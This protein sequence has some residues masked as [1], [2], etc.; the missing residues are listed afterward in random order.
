MWKYVKNLVQVTQV[1]NLSTCSHNFAYS[2]GG[3]VSKNGFFKKKSTY[4]EDDDFEHS[5]R[6]S[7]R[8]SPYR[9]NSDSERFS[10]VSENRNF[11]YGSNQGESNFSERIR[12]SSRREDPFN[13]GSRGQHRE[14]K[15]ANLE[16]IGIPSKWKV[17]AGFVKE[18]DRLRNK[19]K[20]Q[21][22]FRFIQKKPEI[23]DP[24]IRRQVKV[25]APHIEP[26][27]FP[28]D[29]D[30]DDEI[31][32]TKFDKLYD[33][34]QRTK[35]SIDELVKL[36]IVK[37]KYFKEPK[38]TSLSWSD[39]EHIR[40]LHSTDPQQWTFET[41]AEQFQI[42]PAVAKAVATAKWI[43]KKSKETESIPLDGK[44]I[45][46]LVN[47][48]EEQERPSKQRHSD[49]S[50]ADKKRMTWQE[51]RAQMG[52]A[53]DEIPQIAKSE[54]SHEQLESNDTDK[55]LVLRY[56]SKDGPSKWASDK[57]TSPELKIEENERGPATVFHY[58]SK[59]GYQV[60]ML[61]RF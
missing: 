58:D 11:R 42:D 30:L 51:L 40:Y 2:K 41:I 22:D 6:A 5:E 10:P 48:S 16:E 56:L 33:S 53:K 31:D 55:D 23:R 39:K 14:E 12:P 37:Q 34:T 43:P 24:G 54:E 18:A 27:N 19:A 59:H 3:S 4:E 28:T 52:D 26:N 9:K 17:G 20:T 50:N 32:P 7:S 47:L 38:E 46:P 36:K 15:N 45:Y 60:C 61:L 25:L 1:R 8:S 57:S 35:Q 49:R 13:A 29:H 21:R 44:E